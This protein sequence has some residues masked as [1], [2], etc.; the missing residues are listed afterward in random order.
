MSK[1]Y[2]WMEV[3]AEWLYSYSPDFAAKVIAQFGGEKPFTELAYTFDESEKEPLARI[4]EV[5]GWT[6]VGFIEKFFA[7]NKTEILNVCKSV[8]NTYGPNSLGMQICELTGYDDAA[9]GLRA[10]DVI[11]SDKVEESPELAKALVWFVAMHCAEEYHRY[12][13]SHSED[14]YFD[15]NDDDWV[16]V[17]ED[18][19]MLDKEGFY[20]RAE[21]P[22]TT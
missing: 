20:V 12:W 19:F 4:Q 11:N 8:G 22:K 15:M 7:D 10:I 9:F 18:G 6:D 3:F 14:D 1:Q 13:L 2:T 5:N 17:D 16:W 21:T